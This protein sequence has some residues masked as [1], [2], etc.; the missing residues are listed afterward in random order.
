MLRLLLF[1][2]TLTNITISLSG[3][4]VLQPKLI[5]FD[6]KGVVFKNEQAF[7]FR[8]Y[9]NGWSFGYYQGEIISYDKTKYYS[10]ELGHLRD[11]RERKQSKS[12]SPISTGNAFV[13]GKINHAVNI[14]GSLGRKRYLSEKAKRRG[15]AVGYSYEFGPSIALMKPYYLSLS[16]PTEVGGLTFEIRNEKFSEENKAVFLDRSRIQGAS[17]Y[18]NGIGEISVIPGVQAKAAAHFAL[19]AFDRYMKTVEAGVQVDVFTKRLPILYETENNTNSA[20]FVK[21]FA[22]VQFGLRKT[23]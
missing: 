2:I 4:R 15:L 1:L 23:K 17:G 9:E 5:E 11:I 3:Q 16:Y 13:L 8:L 22:V 20:I 6:T 7:T 12:F 21:L 18:F 10:I 14:R 19:G